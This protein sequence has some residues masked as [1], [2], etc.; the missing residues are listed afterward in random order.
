MKSIMSK[1]EKRIWSKLLTIEVAQNCYS[2]AG[3]RTL[4]H[5]NIGYYLLTVIWAALYNI[6]SQW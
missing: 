1:I 3:I 4:Y 2:L 6:S 5:T